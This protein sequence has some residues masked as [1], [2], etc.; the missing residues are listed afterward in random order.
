MWRRCEGCLLAAL[1][2]QLL[3][4]ERELRD[5]V[6]WLEANLRVDVDARIHVFELTIRALGAL[7]T[8]PTM[9]FALHSSIEK[10]RLHACPLPANRK[11]V[12]S[13]SHI[14]QSG[15]SCPLGLLPSLP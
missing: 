3:G 14:P 13:A 11:A 9:R 7:P 15:S 1:P 4:G 8:H 10:F 2:V 12:R 6:A 5:A